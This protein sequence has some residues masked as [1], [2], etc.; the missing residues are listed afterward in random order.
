MPEHGET[1]EWDPDGILPPMPGG[2]GHFDRRR[3][4]AK[5]APLASLASSSPTG[6]LPSDPF[7]DL[8]APRKSSPRSSPT[9]SI[10]PPP[11][12]DQRGAQRGFGEVH[13]TPEDTLGARVESAF[14]ETFWGERGVPRV[15]D[16]FRRLRDGE[17][18]IKLWP[19]LGLQRAGSY[20]AGLSAIPFPEVHSGAYPWLVQLEAHSHIIQKE[21]TEAMT[22]GEG[23][24]SKGN[25]VWVPAAREE[26]IAYGPNWRTL[27]LQDRGLWEEANCKLFPKTVKLLKELDGEIDICLYLYI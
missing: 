16:S 11:V 22:D 10:V 18:W 4:T 5:G 3:S 8:L 21:F 6:T 24:Q 26:A 27:V 7:P 14:L 12:S 23:L 15:L 13:G 17:E 20:I 25:R 9:G 2:G 1:A 19:G